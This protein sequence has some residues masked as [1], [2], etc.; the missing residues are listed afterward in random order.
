MQA[1]TPRATLDYDAIRQG[2][3]NGDGRTDFV[4]S[5]QG[6]VRD[7]IGRD[8]RYW[9]GANP[10]SSSALK[11]LARDGLGYPGAS[12]AANHLNE[13][14]YLIGDVNGDGS[15]DY[16][17][18]YLG[19]AGARINVSMGTLGGLGPIIAHTNSSGAM[20]DNANGYA[21]NKWHAV[22]ADVNGDGLQDLAYAKY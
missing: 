4:L 5:Y 10:T 13:W 9:L 12:L 17:Q 20:P 14:E 1:V 8:V 7:G 21:Y 19:S 2:D 15:D 16:V 22:L 6:A 3:V 11:L 18:V